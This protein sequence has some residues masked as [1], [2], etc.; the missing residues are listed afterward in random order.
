M[1]L[2]TRG[3]TF[4]SVIGLNKTNLLLENYCDLLLEAEVNMSGDRISTE[5]Q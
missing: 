3:E 5:K 4:Q 2:R 1:K